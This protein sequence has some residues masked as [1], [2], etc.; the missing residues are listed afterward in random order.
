LAFPE[1]A[2]GTLKVMPVEGGEPRAIHT[3]EEGT[4][5]TS[6][7]WSH[8][9]KYLFISKV[10]K[11]EDKT[12]KL[13]LWRISMDGGTPVKYPLVVQGMG[14]LSIHPDGKQIAFSDWKVDSA[15]YVMENFL[16]EKK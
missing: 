5:C 4:W 9:G 1:W 2:D 13:E 15:T 8:D 14:D 12:G 3:F 10:P 6:V 11:G 7:A 16:P